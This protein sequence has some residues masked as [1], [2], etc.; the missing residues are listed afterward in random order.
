MLAIYALRGVVESK[1]RVIEITAQNL[2]DAQRLAVSSARKSSSIRGYL[3]S[4]QPRQLELVQDRRAMF[5]ATLPRMRA[6]TLGPEARRLLDE[7]E[8]HEAEHEAA[9]QRVIAMRRDDAPPAEILRAFDEQVQ[10]KLDALVRTVDAF[11]VLGERS[12]AQDTDAANE[13]ANFAIS[14]IVVLY[15]LVMTLKAGLAAFL[16]GSLSRRIGTAVGQVQ[17]SAAELQSGANQQATATREQATAMREIEATITE[18]LA[19]ARQ[20]AQT[21]QQV[22]QVAEQA[23]SAARSGDV[24]VNRTYESIASIRRQVDL[25]VSHMQ[26][27]GKKSQRIGAVLDIVAELAEQ[28]NIL[29]INATLEAA[30][31]GEAG[32]RF[33]VVADEIRKL[34]DRVAG[35][36]KEIRALIDD[37]R[38]SVNTTVMSTETGSKAVDSGSRQ[39]SGVAQ[40]FKQIV[41]LAGTTTNAAREIELSTKQQSTAVEQVNLA[42]FGVVQATKETEVSS[43]Q[44]LQTAKQLSSLSSD[45]LRMVQQRAHA[46]SARAS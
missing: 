3:L 20:I 26:D 4:K 42:I 27:L 8:R 13:R 38:S 16:S 19:T 41:E 11:T 32:K 10:P 36:T 17:T 7:A 6:R 2:T 31:A 29:A 21:A 44:V 18:L 37:V 43:G 24:T 15:A 14:L 35:S 25:L 46:H 9:A 5:L 1:D 34:A 23:A 45:L 39:F 40:A 12:L 28:T 22:A 33:A 30:G